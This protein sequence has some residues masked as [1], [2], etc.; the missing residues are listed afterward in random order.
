MPSEMEFVTFKE[1]VEG[2]PAVEDTSSSDKAVFCNASD[3][4]RSLPN[5]VLAKVKDSV[6]KTFVPASTDALE[7]SVYGDDK[8]VK[9]DG[10]L[11]SNT[12]Y[13]ISVPYE[14]K[15]GETVVFYVCSGYTGSNSFPIYKTNQSTLDE[16]STFE[17]LG[18][19]AGVV[20]AYKKYEYTNNTG[21]DI[22]VVCNNRDGTPGTPTISIGVYRQDAPTF[23]EFNSAMNGKADKETYSL[24]EGYSSYTNGVGKAIDGYYL[25]ASATLHADANYYISDS[26]ELKD[27]ETISCTDIINNIAYP[28]F[29]ANTKTITTSTTF[30]ALGTGK[31]S[32]PSYT[33]NS[34][35]TLYVVFCQRVGSTTPVHFTI[36]KYGVNA[37]TYSE[38]VQANRITKG[39]KEINAF[40]YYDLNS[41]GV[42][43]NDGAYN[44]TSNY[45]NVRFR[46]EPWMKKLLIVTSNNTLN[47]LNVAFFTTPVFDKNNCQA[48]FISG[49]DFYGTDV[50][51][52]VEIPDT[53][54]YIFVASLKSYG[55]IKKLSIL[56]SYDDLSVLSFNKDIVD[57]VYA[58]NMTRGATPVLSLLHFSDIHGIKRNLENIVKVKN[59]Y[60]DIIADVIDTGDDVAD[61][62]SDEDIFSGVDGA[63][64]ILRCI[65]NHDNATKTGGVYDFNAKTASECYGKFFAPFIANWGVT[66]TENLCYYYKDYV[67]QGIRLIVLDAMHND[68]TQEAWLDSVLADAKTNGLAVV[69]ANHYMRTID[70]FQTPFNDAS[71]S[72]SNMPVSWAESVSTFIEGGGE[73]I[74]WICGHTHRDSVGTIQGYE[75][76]VM[77]VIDTAATGRSTTSNTY[78][79]YYTRS[80][81]LMNVVSIDKNNTTIKVVRIGARERDDMQVIDSMVINYSERTLIR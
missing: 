43:Q 10:T 19:D 53:C 36:S 41:Y 76:Q 8:Y 9:S 26:I 18:T 31:T 24:N 69:C 35:S 44:S 48:A 64:N 33:N 3:G 22:Y 46:R 25:D 56:G 5:T 74:C 73:F 42:I 80:Q 72:S 23:Q 1:F 61:Q 6:M 40:D 20:D 13:F 79:K 17:I 66:Y 52:V 4:P 65:G 21:S 27:R 15:N 38:F 81:D 14:I 57:K 45:E 68:A 11:G 51:S 16:N 29:S 70:V 12:A 50:E 58:S 75:N 7:R 2:L 54:N 34:G 59:Y 47:R 39:V 63:E 28:L 55:E 71:P 49:K 32:T 77:I 30:T 62:F 67:A 37:P 78:R 60:S